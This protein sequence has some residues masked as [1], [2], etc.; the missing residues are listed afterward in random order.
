MWVAFFVD[1]GDGCGGCGLLP[2]DYVNRL[3]FLENFAP[4]MAQLVCF[5]AKNCP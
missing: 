4:E 3:T 5:F 1:G 2:P